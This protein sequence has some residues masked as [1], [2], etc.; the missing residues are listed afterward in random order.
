MIRGDGHI[1]QLPMCL[2]SVYRFANCKLTGVCYPFSGYPPHHL[3]GINLPAI[4]PDLHCMQ[5]DQDILWL[6]LFLT[7][8][9]DSYF[10][11][12][13]CSL[14]NFCVQDFDVY[15]MIGSCYCCGGQL[16]L[17]CQP[18]LFYI[19]YIWGRRGRDRMVVGFTT[20]YAIS[21]YHL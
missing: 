13:A 15:Q 19:L 11:R 10:F 4:S 5:S 20:T 14:C 2:S 8:I 18:S 17:Y 21:A 9:Q 1:K 6:D 3:K 12:H 7:I 16:Y